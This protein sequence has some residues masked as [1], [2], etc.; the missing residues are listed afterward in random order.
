MDMCIR[1]S[2][3][4]YENEAPRLLEESLRSATIGRSGVG[5]ERTTRL[6]TEMTLTT[7]SPEK[8]DSG[9]LL[10]SLYP[11]QPIEKLGMLPVLV[12]NGY[13][14]SDPPLDRKLLRLDVLGSRHE[15]A[16]TILVSVC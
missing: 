8:S 9:E 6:Q 4:E 2:G 11:S 13:R 16:L 3:S 1:L 5:Q 10:T 14:R 7:L 15:E 12:I